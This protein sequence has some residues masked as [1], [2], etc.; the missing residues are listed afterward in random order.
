MRILPAVL[1]LLAVLVSPLASARAAPLEEPPP[2]AVPA[3]RSEV[4]VVRAIKFSLAEKGW[5]VESEK[6]GSISASHSPRKH[7]AR[8]EI[9]TAAGQVTIKYVD[10]VNLNFAQKGDKRE[11]HPAYN[12]WVTALHDQIARNVAQGVAADA[13][14]P[15]VNDGKTRN[16]PPAEKFSNFGRFELAEA[17]MGPPYAGQKPNEDARANIQHSLVEKLGTT[18]NEWG[19]AAKPD[20]RVLRVEPNVDHI[21]FIG[22]A[23]RLFV[24]RMAGRSSVILKVRFVDV[25]TGAVVA[26][27]EFYLEAEPANGFSA[28]ARDY[29][30]LENIA[31]A[32]AEYT[33]ANYTEAVGG[34]FRAPADFK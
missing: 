29:K 4:D 31:A 32:V 14:M 10:S 33:K 23:A 15:A 22:T 21:R 11:I 3:E 12:E 1:A 26:E 20:A 19:A 27:P 24:G 7:V 9:T 34:G 8:V 18:L 2:I 28:S 25:A 5:V 6:P 17:T 16:P 13:A 30:M